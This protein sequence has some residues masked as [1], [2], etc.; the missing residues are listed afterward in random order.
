MVI[1]LITVSTTWGGLAKTARGNTSHEVLHAKGRTNVTLLLLI[2]GAAFVHAL[3]VIEGKLKD[4][5]P[6]T[7]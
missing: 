4:P 3:I 1:G 5:G 6:A 2:V 7:D